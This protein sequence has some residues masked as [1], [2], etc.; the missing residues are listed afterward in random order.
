MQRP[1]ADRFSVS[2]LQPTFEI[3]ERSHSLEPLS[4]SYPCLVTVLI[5]CFED[6]FSPAISAA[7]VLLSFL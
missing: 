4:S 1:H 3:T 5:R 7:A 6:R 2:W